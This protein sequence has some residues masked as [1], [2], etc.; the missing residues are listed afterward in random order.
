MKLNEVHYPHEYSVCL[1]GEDVGI[2]KDMWAAKAVQQAMQD[3]GRETVAKAQANDDVFVEC[4]L[5]PSAQDG[6]A[7]R[8]NEYGL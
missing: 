1:D 2:F 7:Y 5:D 3:L 6:L 4:R 8:R